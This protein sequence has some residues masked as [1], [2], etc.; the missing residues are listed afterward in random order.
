MIW[1]V[2]ENRSDSPLVDMKMMRIPAVWSTNLAALLFG[3]GM[4]AMFVTLPQ[5]TETP[6]HAGYGFGA[7]VTQSGL[8]LAPF[9]AAMVIV[10][11]MTGRLSKAF[12]SKM[13]L[14]AGSLFTASSYL[15]LIA[16]PHRA[17][18]DL[19]RH[20]AARHRDRPGLRQHGEP[21]H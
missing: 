18:V 13:V 7:S 2:S 4:F 3:F 16:G 6:T 17:M 9:A 11:P 1:A 10:A 19:R 21:D 15:L 20:G 14:V 5:F 8:Y 12:G